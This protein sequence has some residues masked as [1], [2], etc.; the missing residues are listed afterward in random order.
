[1]IIASKALDGLHRKHTQQKHSNLCS[2]KKKNAK[3]KIINAG[4]EGAHESELQTVK[5]KKLTYAL[6]WSIRKYENKNGI[7][8]K[9]T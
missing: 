7:K 6:L 9:L 5:K 8:K 2:K 4:Q 1:M 3:R